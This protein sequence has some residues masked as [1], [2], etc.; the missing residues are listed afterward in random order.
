MYESEAIRSQFI[1]YDIFNWCTG[2]PVEVD[3]SSGFYVYLAFI[4]WLCVHM[5]IEGVGTALAGP[6][7]AG[8]L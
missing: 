2:W 8:P 3:S 1:G 7:L 4:F 5:Y 6:V